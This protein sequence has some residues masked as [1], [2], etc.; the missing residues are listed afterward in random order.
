MG[1]PKVE[2]LPE[3]ILACPLSEGA[4]INPAKLL[5]AQEYAASQGLPAP[6]NVLIP[7]TKGF[8]SAVSIMRDFVPAI[9]DTTVIIPKDSPAP[10]ML[11]ILKGQ[12]SVV[13]VRI[14]RHA[15]S[16]MPKSDEDV[17]KWCKDIFVA[18]DALLDKHIATGTFDEEI[19]PIGR[20][21]KSLLVVL[22][23]SC[24]LLYGACRFLQWTQL[25][26][27]WKGV[28]L[29]VAGLTLVTGIMHVFV[30]FSQSERSSSAR[31]ARNRVKKD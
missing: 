5:A 17:S 9:Y 22:S 8:V 15:M 31:A 25:L 12:S 23:W 18:K 19:R 24:L 10:T 16:D 21:I 14:K 13:H 3:I 29:F 1:S 4:R 30:L 7:R 11:R 26:S 28:I 20:P 6:R 2:E 27:T